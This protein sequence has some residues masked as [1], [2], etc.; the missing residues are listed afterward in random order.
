MKGLRFDDVGKNSVIMVF[1]NGMMM[2]DY[3]VWYFCI[4]SFVFF[5]VVLGIGVVFGVVIILN[6]VGYII[7]FE[8]GFFLV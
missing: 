1:F 4:K 3:I 8:S 2:K 7:N 5:F 6:V